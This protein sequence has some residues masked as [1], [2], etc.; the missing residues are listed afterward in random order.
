MDNV[1][2]ED[3]TTVPEPSSVTHLLAIGITG[4][5]RLQVCAGEKEPLPYKSVWNECLLLVAGAPTRY[6]ARQVTPSPGCR[7][8]S[9]PSRSAPETSQS[10]AH[11]ILP[12][13][14]RSALRADRPRLPRRWLGLFQPSRPATCG[15][16]GDFGSCL[17]RWRSSSSSQGAGCR[18]DLGGMNNAAC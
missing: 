3:I 14:A 7:P 5:R 13:L 8:A 6:R 11:L 15:Q 4:I 18:S 9:R 12:R 1:D 2:L 10:S 17:A 16:A